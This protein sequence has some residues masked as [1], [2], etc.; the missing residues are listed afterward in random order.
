MKAA[1][2]VDEIN[3]VKQLHEIGIQGIRPWVQFYRA[4]HTV[5]RK[6]FGQADVGYHFYGSLPPKDVAGSKYFDRKRFFQAL[7]R[8]GIQVHQGICISDRTGNLMEK[9]VD[10]SIG[11]DLFEFSLNEFDLLFVFS[12]DTDLVPAIQRA[13]LRSKVV[14]VVSRLQPARLFKEMADGILFLEDVIGLIGKE[15]LIPRKQNNPLKERVNHV[16]HN[17]RN[18]PERIA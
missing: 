7:E 11:L 9:G 5:L 2:L 14:A 8:D 17:H 3:A 18:Q 13:K 15:H 1:I 12:G 6:D 16:Q 4:I 10:M